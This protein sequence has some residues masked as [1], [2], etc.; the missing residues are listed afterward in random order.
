MRNERSAAVTT[1]R[2]PTIHPMPLVRVD[3]ALLALREGALHV[4][5]G[6]REEEPFANQL[7]L[8]GGVLRID[9][10]ASLEA[11]AR[12]VAQERLLVEL[13]NLDQVGAVGEP[14]RD[15][16]APWAIS[17]VY[18]S[19]VDA[20]RLAVEPGKRV[21]ALDWVPVDRAQR[22]RKLAFDHARLIGMAVD[23]ARREVLDM[24]FPPGWLPVTFTLGELQA[25]SQAVLGEPLDKVTFRRRIEARGLVEPVEGE[26]RAGGA[27]RPA[28]VYM[29]R[30]RCVSE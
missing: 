10:D 16:R 23:A 2:Q 20:E 3:V 25:L 19:L 29:L 7:G 27:H 18:R 17:I 13:P 4:L 11:A 28:Q 8:P 6:L 1:K 5:L 15:P 22:D 24:N 9:L 12:R 30:S 26:M 21:A 14:A